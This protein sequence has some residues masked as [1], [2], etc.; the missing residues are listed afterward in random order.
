VPKISAGLVMFHR[1]GSTLR[2]LLVHPGGPFFQHRDEGVWTIPKGELDGPEDPL[3]AA[4][5]EFAEETSLTPSGPF[6]PLGSIK[7]KAGKTVH[8]WAFEGTCDPASLKS[9]QF[10]LEWP[11]KSGHHQQFPEVDRAE[12]F[13]IE[14]ARGKINPAQFP[15][16]E[17]LQQTIARQPV[18]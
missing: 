13:T 4:Q 9:N 12:F 6:L 17:S 16:L 14:E 1:D 2:V 3:A 7:Q 8:A 5:R 18:S 11:P 15:L 10:D